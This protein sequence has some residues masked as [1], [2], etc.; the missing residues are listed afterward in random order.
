MKKISDIKF[1]EMSVRQK[2]SFANAVTYPKECSPENEKYIFDQIKNRA[3][4]AI[5]IQMG[6]E[7]GGTELVRERIKRVREAADYPI[8]IMTDA[9][10]GMGEYKIGHHGPLACTGKEE[11]AYAFGK[12][13]GVTARE[14]GYN[15]VCNPLLDLGKNG[16][17]RALSS[18][19]HT[20]AKFAAAEARGM[21]DAGILT[22]GKHYPSARNDL[23][24]DTHMVE[25]FSDQT[26]EE[27]LDES[28]YAYLELIREGLLDG[29]MAGHSKL[30]KIDPTAPACLSKPVIDVIRERGYDGF[31]ITDALCMMG[32][33]AKFGKV[34]NVTFVVHNRLFKKPLRNAIFGS[35]PICKR[36]YRDVTFRIS[37]L[38]FESIV[39]RRVFIFDNAVS[40]IR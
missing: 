23:N 4:G 40:N 14:F 34:V 9:E 13:V 18:D 25:G 20:V 39:F 36:A 21:H 6:N 12:A 27:L 15:A 5:W 38:V 7:G 16:S 1:E 26:K 11:Y 28:L 2:L 8:I 33:R 10:S 22:V 17:V 32:I 19:K 35:Y 31:I 24:L 30:R 29:I 37:Y 3:M